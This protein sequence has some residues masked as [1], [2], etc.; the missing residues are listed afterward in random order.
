MCRDLPDFPRDAQ[1]GQ[2]RIRGARGDAHGDVQG[3][4]RLGARLRQQAERVAELEDALRLAEDE[5]LARRAAA[6]AARAAGA[7]RARVGARPYAA[8]LASTEP[9]YA[10]STS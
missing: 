2:G 4:R 7:R 1:H 10:A 5:L 8:W 3:E 9:R 6:A